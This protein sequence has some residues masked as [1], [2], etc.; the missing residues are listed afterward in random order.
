MYDKIMNPK[1]GRKVNIN[2]KLGRQILRNYLDV[3]QG[4]ARN[5]LPNF[6]IKSLSSLP[7]AQSGGAAANEEK[8]RELD[9]KVSKNSDKIIILDNRTKTIPPGTAEKVS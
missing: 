2:G 7:T 1:T 6:A 4:G 9:K 3:L 8:I 5:Q